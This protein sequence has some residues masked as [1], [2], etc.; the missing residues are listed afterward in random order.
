MDIDFT[1]ICPVVPSAICSR[2]F[3]SGFQETLKPSVPG[4]TKPRSYVANAAGTQRLRFSL[5]LV[6]SLFNSLFS[7]NKYCSLPHVKWDCLTFLFSPGDMGSF[8]IQIIYIKLLTIG[9]KYLV[10]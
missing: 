7:L 10:Y 6:D 8:G 2:R 1:S 9:D 5:V 3:D 4:F